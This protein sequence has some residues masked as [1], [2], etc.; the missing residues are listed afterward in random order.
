M[1]FLWSLQWCPAM[2]WFNDKRVEKDRKDKKHLVTIVG[3][4]KQMPWGTL[5]TTPF[6]LAYFCF[7]KD[8]E[9]FLNLTSNALKV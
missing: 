8:N 3:K 9:G 6:L 5:D 4:K 7:G 2:E 1:S